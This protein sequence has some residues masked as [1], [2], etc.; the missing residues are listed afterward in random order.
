MCQNVFS[1]FVKRGDTL[2]TNEVFLKTYAPANSKQT[3]MHI[4]IYS[5][6]ETDV[7][8]TT[9]MRPKSSST[10]L[11]DVQKVGELIVPFQNDQEGAQG[12][13]TKR[14]PE[15]N[16][17]VPFDFNHTEIQAKGYDPISMNE[18]KVVL[19]FLSA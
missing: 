14:N 2:N 8:Y 7:W 9:G 1:T 15:R 5:S 10:D 11:V 12:N 13:D 18:V 16:I 4:D 3:R 17:D 6:P 19:D